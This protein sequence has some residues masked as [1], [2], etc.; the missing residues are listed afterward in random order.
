MKTNL[1]NP[2]L[3]TD[4]YKVG[5]KDQY[6][7][8]TQKVYSTLI[9]RSNKWMPWADKAIFFGLQ[10]FIKKYLIEDMNVHFFGRSKKEIKQ[11]YS[12]FM[13]STLGIKNFNT[14]HIED[15]HDLGY[16]PLEIKALPEGTSVPMRVP[17]LSLENTHKD[18]FWVT[19]YFETLIS[20]IVWKTVTSATISHKYRK[21]FEKYAELTG[22][23]KGFVGFQGHDFSYRGM[24]G[25]EAAQLSGSGHLVNFVGTDTIPAISYL[26]NYYLADITKGLVGTSIPATEHSVMCAGGYIQLD[27]LVSF[28]ILG[29]SLVH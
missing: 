15:L 25:D 4:F 2:I 10:G 9:P 17:M 18:F 24:A 16:I 28:P 27:L 13:E 5:H 29:I 3:K 8:G 26:E 11:E 22:Y 19:N 7:K 12:R 1:Q 14:K 21:E 20:S 6:P 23:D